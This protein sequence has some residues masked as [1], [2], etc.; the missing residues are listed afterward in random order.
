MPSLSNLAPR[1]AGP[2]PMLPRSPSPRSGV[3]SPHR[4]SILC[5]PTTAYPDSS[6]SSSFPCICTSTCTDPSSRYHRHHHHSFLNMTHEAL[7]GASLGCLLSLPFPL[8]HVVAVTEGVC[9]GIIKGKVSETLGL[10]G[11]GNDSRPV[12]LSDPP[13]KHIPLL[14]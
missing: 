11:N 3:T 2:H 6:V 7:L 8:S 13:A 14:K 1:Y 4:T 12:Q 10:Q 9:A 5:A